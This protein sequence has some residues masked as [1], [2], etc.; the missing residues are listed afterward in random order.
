M[1]TPNDSCQPRCATTHLA[2]SS[3][4]APN[5]VI[6]DDH[7]AFRSSASLMLR[8]EGF[9]VVG[10]AVDGASALEQAQ[11]LRPMWC[12]WMSACPTSEASRSRRSSHAGSIARSSSSCRGRSRD[13]DHSHP[14]GPR[15]RG[16]R[17]PPQGGADGRHAEEPAGPDVKA[18]WR[19]VIVWAL[20][21]LVGLV[22]TWVAYG[23]R[24][25][26]QT[27]GRDPARLWVADLV[28]GWIVQTAGLIAWWRMPSSRIG[29]LLVA[30]GVAWFIGNGAVS[31]LAW[32]AEASERLRF[33]YRAFVIH[34]LVTY[35]TGRAES[36]E[37]AGRRRHGLCRRAPPARLGGP[38]GHRHRGPHGGGGLRPA[39]PCHRGAGATRPLPSPCGSP[40][41]SPHWSA[42]RLS[43]DGGGR[44]GWPIASS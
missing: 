20:G 40:A 6:V 37:R 41:S 14:R 25:R 39:V 38:P 24:G 17:L 35:P 29:P 23:P 19:A 7:P 3:H 42:C 44:A 43:A 5:N 16:P 31:N 21:L 26:R 2:P 27:G 1:T 18:P 32:I 12:C 33:L 15:S 10:E 8:A 11:R 4:C 22:A 28:T 9:D 13:H 30:S 34:A 36:P